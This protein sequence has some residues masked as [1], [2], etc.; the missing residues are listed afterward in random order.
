MG[1]SGKS[2]SSGGKKILIGIAIVVLVAILVVVILLC[3]PPN[4]YNAIET[5]NR[6][7]QSSFLKNN[8]ESADFSDFRSKLGKNTTLKSY[9]TEVSDIRQLTLDVN[10]ILSFY[11][12]HIVRQDYLNILLIYLNFSKYPKYIYLLIEQFFCH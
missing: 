6:S 3:I 5:L 7:T 2:G 12:Y 1:K 4:T 9:S 8:S 11:N 10:N